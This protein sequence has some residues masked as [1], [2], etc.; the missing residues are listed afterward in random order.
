MGNNGSSTVRPPASQT[1]RQG[2]VITS[3]DRVQLELKLQRDKIMA[4]IRKYE[5]AAEGEHVRA[6]ELLRNGKR[7]LALY[8]LKRRK[9][10]MSQITLVTSMLEN[11]ERLICTVEFAQIEREVVDALKCGKD[12]LSKLNAILNMDDVLELMDST[13]DVVEESKQINEILAQQLIVYDESELLSELCSAEGQVSDLTSLKSM[14]V[15]VSQLPS[16]QRV[17]ERATLEDDERVR[18]AA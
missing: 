7:E 12:E 2:A 13:A 15:P 5:R 10:Q 8:C 3:L 18:L 16:E 14:V 9:A 1:K 17:R 6:A 11:V 4:A